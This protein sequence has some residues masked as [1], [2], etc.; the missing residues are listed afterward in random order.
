M[1]I[2]TRTE[3]LIALDALTAEST[4]SDVVSFGCAEGAIGGVP[5]DLSS[6][7]WDDS[8]LQIVGSGPDGT[9]WVARRSAHLAEW[10]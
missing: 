5:L 3:W 10:I 7:E 4:P 2:T 6:P 8:R 1:T 9:P